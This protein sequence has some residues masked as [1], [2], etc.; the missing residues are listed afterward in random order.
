MTPTKK[1]I[2][3]NYLDS[4]IITTLSDNSNLRVEERGEDGENGTGYYRAFHSSDKSN[5]GF[6]GD[7]GK[8]KDG[9]TIETITSEI[10]LWMEDNMLD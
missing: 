4:V 10:A 9:E 3:R 6:E 7:R 1:Q 5:A 2:E 8:I